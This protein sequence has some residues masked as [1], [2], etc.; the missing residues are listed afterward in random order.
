MRTSN[1]IGQEQLSGLIYSADSNLKDTSCL[2]ESKD[3][4]NFMGDHSLDYKG[5]Q[6]RLT[7]VMAFG[8][9]SQEPAGLGADQGPTHTL[10]T[11]A[12]DELYVLVMSFCHVIEIFF[13]PYYP[14]EVTYD[15]HQDMMLLS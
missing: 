9:A 13:Q 1:N 2:S 12:V 3:L 5:D 7:D 4:K 14:Q 6:S 11:K 15:L 8:K 10:S